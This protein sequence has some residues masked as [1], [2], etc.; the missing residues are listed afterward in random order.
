VSCVEYGNAERI[1]QMFS[2]MEESPGSVPAVASESL[3][4]FKNICM[5]SVGIISRAAM[6]GGL[7]EDVVYEMST[8]YLT[9]FEILDNFTDIY[10]QFKAMVIDFTRRTSRTRS[11]ITF[12]SPFA[13]KISRIVASRIYEKLSPTVI[14]DTLGMNLSHLCRNFKE[15][16]G[17]TVT[18]YINEIK[19]DEAKRLLRNTNMAIMDISLKLGYGTQSYFQ[20]LFKKTAGVT[21]TEYR[22]QGKQLRGYPTIAM[23]HEQE[24]ASPNNNGESKFK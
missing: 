24:L 22:N 21:P 17:K 5:F 20:N 1:K 8:H 10:G 2:D 12:S 18:E 11:A 13:A 16:T 4:A 23:P 15:S 9:R 6:N 19:M 3:R 14:A 7:Y